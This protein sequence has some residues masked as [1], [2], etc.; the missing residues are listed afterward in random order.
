MLCLCV[1]PLFRD[2]L[3]QGF[4]Q[5]TVLLLLLQETT[6]VVVVF[7]STKR[8]KKCINQIS[9]DAKLAIVSS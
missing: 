1:F 4:I 9:I 5:A 8:E 2:K 3:I 7:A 6:S